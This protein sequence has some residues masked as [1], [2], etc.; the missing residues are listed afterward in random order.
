MVVDGDSQ[1]TK[2]KKKKKKNN[3]SNDKSIQ[4]NKRIKKKEIKKPT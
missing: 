4:I 1:F 3:H 2:K